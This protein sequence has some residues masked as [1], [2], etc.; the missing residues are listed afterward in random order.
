MC[1]WNSKLRHDAEVA[2][3]AAQR[4]E[5]VGVLGRAWHAPAAPSASTTSAARQ[6]VD[7][8]PVLAH[9]PAD[10]AAEREPADAGVGDLAGRDG[11]PVLLRRGVELAE[12][13]AAADP[14]DAALASTS[15]PFS[16]R[17]SMQSAPSRTERPE[18]ECPPARTVNGRPAARAAR[19]AAATS[20][21]SVAYA[22]AAGRRSMAPFQ[23]GAGGVV[24]GVARLDE[25]GRRSRGRGGRRRRRCV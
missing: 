7:R 12:Q 23:P 10:A 21:A 3:A 6:R 18:T 14:H 19:I 15:T 5:Q 20:S 4:P 8:Q 17:R 24:V 16:A 25:R 22:T 13:R 9:Q 1:A 2:A 11:E